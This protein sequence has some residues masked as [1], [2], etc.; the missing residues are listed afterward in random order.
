MQSTWA[1]RGTALVYVRLNPHSGLA[2]AFTRITSAG[3]RRRIVKLVEEL[4]GPE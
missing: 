1:Q 4:A 3:L 2:K